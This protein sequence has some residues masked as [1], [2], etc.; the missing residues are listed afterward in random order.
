MTIVKRPKKI[1]IKIRK[2]GREK[3]WGQAWQGE[4]LIEIDP[5]QKSKGFM[6]TAI[7]EALHILFPKLSEKQ[8]ITKSRAITDVL[9]RLNIRR[10]ME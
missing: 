5:R 9:W 8:I 2:L 10:I 3:A 7:H 1:K 6:E 4:S